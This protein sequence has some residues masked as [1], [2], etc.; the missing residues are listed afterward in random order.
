[1]EKLLFG[2]KMQI[3]TSIKISKKKLTDSKKIALA[4]P[5]LAPYGNAADEFLKP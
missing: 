5:K 3:L 1:M 4:N 2:I